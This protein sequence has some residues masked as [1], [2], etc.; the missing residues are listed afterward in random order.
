[1][2]VI[3]IIITGF[4]PLSFMLGLWVGRR[5]CASGRAAQRVLSVNRGIY[6]TFS[7]TG[8]TTEK[9]FGLL[10]ADSLGKAVEQLLRSDSG[11]I[12]LHATD[13]ETGV[14]RYVGVSKSKPGLTVR[15]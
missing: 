6:G 8:Y 7:K 13:K 2:W 1:M 15:F 12:H 3:G 5:E 4:V 9:G 14:R 11:V 10:G